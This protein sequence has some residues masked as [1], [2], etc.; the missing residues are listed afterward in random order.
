MNYTKSCIEPA[1]PSKFQ[2]PAIDLA[3]AL[4]AFKAAQYFTP[5]KINE[6]QPSTTNIDTLIVTKF[7]FLDLV[8]ML[9][10]SRHLS[11]AAD[12]SPD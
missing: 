8:R 12:L 5:S 1:Y 3:T 2:S 6:L 10:N 4:S 11:K 9:Q 7:P